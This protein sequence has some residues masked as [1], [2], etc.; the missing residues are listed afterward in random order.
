MKRRPPQASLRPPRAILPTDRKRILAALNLHCR[1]SER[2]DVSI[3]ALRLRAI[4]LLAASAGLRISEV[5]K[6]N[7]PQVLEDPSAK[8]WRLLPLVYLRPAQSKGRRVGDHQWD[9]AGTIAVT[10]DARSALRAYMLELR[11][12]EWTAVPPSRDQPLFVA[13]RRNRKSKRKGQA[14]G[15]LAIRSLQYQWQAFQRAIGITSPYHFHDLRHT[16]LTRMAELSHG[17]TQ[18]VARFG[19]CDLQTAMRYVHLPPGKLAE[20]RNDL[21]FR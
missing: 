17:N 4:V 13:L 11:R 12:R 21:A 8:R 5:C 2:G 20:M 7:L 10:D 6:L 18:L 16:A 19:R 9:S 15:R 14:H 3:A 1:P